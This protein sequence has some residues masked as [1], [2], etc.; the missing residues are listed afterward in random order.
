VYKKIIMYIIIG[1]TIFCAGGGS[2]WWY[3]Q[4][5][6]ARYKT[7]INEITDRNTTLR[8]TN[9][10]LI[11]LNTSITER[12]Q[13]QSIRIEEAKR[14]IDDIEREFGETEATISGII[15]AIDDIIE[16]VSDL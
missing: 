7:T 2:V 6:I 11:I 4:R 13:A 9:N 12:E 10:S 3:Y 16:A 8:E 15:T 5:Q 1:L 14:I